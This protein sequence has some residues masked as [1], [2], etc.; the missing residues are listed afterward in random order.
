ML[1]FARVFGDAGVVQNLNGSGGAEV[2]PILQD[3]DDFLVARDFDE[4]RAFA[5]AAAGT[6]DRVAVGQARAGLRVDETIRLGQFVGLEFPN[7]SALRVDFARELVLLVDNEGCC[8]SSGGSRPTGW[9]FR[10]ARF[11]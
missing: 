5:V 2:C 11:L 4:L 3:P 10:S 9:K 8:R 7:G 1:R 6:D